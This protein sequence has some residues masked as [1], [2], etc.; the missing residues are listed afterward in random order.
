MHKIR[1][2]DVAPWV[3]M[4]M[5]VGL[6]FLP[7]CTSIIARGNAAKMIESEAVVAT[8]TVEAARVGP[9]FME[10]SEAVSRVQGNAQAFRRWADTATINLFA[11]LFGPKEI[12]AT[13]KWYGHIQRNAI[14]AEEDAKRATTRPALAPGYLIDQSK[15]VLILKAVKDGVAPPE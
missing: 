5:G 9:I 15:R 8:G 10:P 12:L 13:A 7:G 3:L 1:I 14:R 11:Y 6:M 4:L 2:R